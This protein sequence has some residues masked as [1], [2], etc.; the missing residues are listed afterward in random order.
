LQEKINDT[1]VLVAMQSMRSVEPNSEIL[2][3][4]Y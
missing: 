1:D 4:Q 3:K 2:I